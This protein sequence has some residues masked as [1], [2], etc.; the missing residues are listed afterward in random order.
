MSEPKCNSCNIS[1]KPLGK[2]GL[3]TGGMNGGWEFIFGAFAD[4]DERVIYLDTYRCEN[5][6]RLEFF[7]F[8]L[9]LPQN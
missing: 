6:G 5:C 3:R 1:L 7:D 8:D 2:I 9:S 4:M